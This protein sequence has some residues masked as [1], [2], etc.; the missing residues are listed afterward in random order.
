MRVKSMYIYV[1][2]VRLYSVCMSVKGV[3]MRVNGLCIRVK[4]A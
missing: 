1:W 2:R 4:G 3:Y